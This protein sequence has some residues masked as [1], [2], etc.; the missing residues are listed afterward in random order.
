M[1]ATTHSD[2][3]QGGA[4]DN[5]RYIRRRP[6]ARREAAERRGALEAMR[7]SLRSPPARRLPPKSAGSWRGSPHQEAQGMQAARRK[8]ATVCIVQLSLKLRLRRPKPQ[9][10]AKSYAAGP[11]K[12]VRWALVVRV[13]RDHRAPREASAPL[14]RSRR[15]A[16]WTGPCR[17]SC[18]PCKAR[19]RPGARRAQENDGRAGATA[20]RVPE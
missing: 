10:E 4:F 11:F 1:S 13:R 9:A 15:A 12:K 2:H 8:R 14:V 17:R 7:R 6:S 16:G 3:S 18:R 19:A 20:A 5:W